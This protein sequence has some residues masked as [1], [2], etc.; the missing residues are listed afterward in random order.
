MPDRDAPARG[1]PA[2]EP[3]TPGSTGLEEASDAQKHER[4][5]R[6]DHQLGSSSR[7]LRVLEEEGDEAAYEAVE[8][9]C[10]GEREAG[11]GQRDQGGLETRMRARQIDS[12]S[13]SIYDAA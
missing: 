3:L 2:F 12:S 8:E 10:L 13:G 5:G 1:R 9:G 4:D 7:R 6:D 11:V